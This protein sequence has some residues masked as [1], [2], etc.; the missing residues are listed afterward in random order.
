MCFKKFFHQICPVKTKQDDNA[1]AT[2]LQSQNLAMHV[3][4]LMSFVVKVDKHKYIKANELIEFMGGR[5]HFLT[6][7]SDLDPELTKCLV[8]Y[9]MVTQ[10]R[11]WGTYFYTKTQVDF[12]D[13]TIH[14]AF[15]KNVV[16]WLEKEFINDKNRPFLIQAIKTVYNNIEK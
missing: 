8:A 16:P 15:D 10:M 7:E 1:V 3:E 14:Y 12:N 2:S 9:K 13:K 5:P 4:E 11:H 6:T